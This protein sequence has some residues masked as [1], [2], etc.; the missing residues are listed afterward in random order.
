M[1]LADSKQTIC[2]K[3]HE[4]VLCHQFLLNFISPIITNIRPTTAIILIP[5]P[6]FPSYFQNEQSRIREYQYISKTVVL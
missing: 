4:R 2:M 3:T 5:L 6:N 1:L